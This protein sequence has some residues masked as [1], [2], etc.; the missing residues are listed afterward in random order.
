MQDSGAAAIFGMLLRA[1][2]IHHEGLACV[3]E[4]NTLPAG[5]LPRQNEGPAGCS[6]DISQDVPGVA[7]SKLVLLHGMSNARIQH[8]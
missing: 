1:P 8:H 7:P 6:R 2:L 5:A 4:H 3:R